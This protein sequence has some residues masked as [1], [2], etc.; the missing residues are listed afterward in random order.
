MW[1]FTDFAD[2]WDSQKNKSEEIL[3]D[4]VS[5]NPNQ[6]GVIVATSVYTSMALGS[7]IVDILRLGDGLSKG[8]WGGAAQDGLR[9]MG[10]AVPAAKGYQVTK[11]VGNIKLANLVLDVGG[12]R[13]S[14]IN[15]TKA[16]VQTG[17]KTSNGK[18]FASVQDYVFQY[19]KDDWLDILSKNYISVENIL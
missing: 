15:S 8:T 19:L 2:W 11:S 6:F 5:R 17:H 12:P 1:F 13:C 18:L 9:V 3:D 10:I 4:F 14:W 16:L 7:G